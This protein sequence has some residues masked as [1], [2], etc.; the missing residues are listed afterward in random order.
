MVKVTNLKNLELITFDT[1]SSTIRLRALS[2]IVSFQLLTEGNQL[3][4][5][6][7]EIEGWQDK[8][9]G[10][11]V[12]NNDQETELLFGEPP[13]V[14]YSIDSGTLRVSFTPE[15]LKSIKDGSTIQAVAYYL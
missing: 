9:E 14:N 7:V 1:T 13:K 6:D 5:L 8:V 2:G 3:S 4:K 10:L 11:S 12:F 15:G